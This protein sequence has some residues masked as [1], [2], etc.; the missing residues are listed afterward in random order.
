MAV[1]YWVEAEKHLSEALESD[2]HPW[3]AKSRQALEGALADVR[4]NVGDIEVGGD[5]GGATVKVNGRDIGTLPLPRPIRVAKGSLDVEVRAPGY[6]S[7]TQTVRIKGGDHL[8]LTF[9]LT[10]VGEANALSR[11]SDEPVAAPP[12]SAL[13]PRGEPLAEV[14]T[15]TVLTGNTLASEPTSERKATDDGARRWQRRL[16]WTAA[17]GGAAG[18][19]L[20]IFETVAWQSKKSD[21]ENHLGPPPGDPQAA[22]S[23]WKRDCGTDTPGRGGAACSSLFDSAKTA[24]TLAIVGWVAGAVLGATATVMFIKSGDE[25]STRR[26]IACAPTLG[27]SG[28]GCRLT[29]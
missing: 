3:V 19:A 7:S 17:I 8:K 26:A 5:V 13:E 2:D 23:N 4:A 9:K 15:P 10:K 27:Q 22:P 1:G 29:F 16:A 24:E 14:S 18:L 28:L 12:R 20:G 6:T 25:T 11:G 21:F